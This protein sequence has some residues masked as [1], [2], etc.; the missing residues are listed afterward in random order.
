MLP[1]AHLNIALLQRE[2]NC[3]L[4]C[5]SVWVNGFLPQ[6]PAFREGWDCRRQ[7]LPELTL[8]PQALAL[9]A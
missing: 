1:E 7:V 9:V 5:T 2:G 3:A 4:A 6:A 8:N